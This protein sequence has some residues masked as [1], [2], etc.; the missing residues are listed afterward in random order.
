MTKI[1]LIQPRHNYAPAEGPGHIYM[2]T[3][4][5]TIAARLL[6][7]GIDVK[8]FDENLNPYSGSSNIVG[9]NLLGAP[10][11]PEAIKLENKI[12]K[13]HPDAK[14]LLGGQVISGL[15]KPQFQKLFGATAFNGNN[16]VVLDSTLGITNNLLKRAEKI[17][18]VPAYE[19][20]DDGD[21]R[22]Y[23]KREIGLYVSQGCRYACDFCPAVR[24]FKDPTTGVVKKVQEVYR[25]QSIIGADLNY[26]V[27]RAKNL[28]L[29]GLSIYMSNL[30]VFQ[31]HGELA[32]FT[33]AARQVRENHPDFK[34]KFRGLSTAE[35][36]VDLSRKHPKTIED[37]VS[38]GFNT[39][40]FGVDGMTPQVWNALHKGMNTED[41]CIE[42]IR[43]ARQDFGITPE[44]LMVFGHMGVDNH[45]TMKLAYKFTVDMVDKYGAIPRPHV[46]K[47]FVPGNKGWKMS[48]NQEAIELMVQSPEL[49][50][51]LDFTALPSRLTHRHKETKRLATKYFLKICYLPSATTLF[52]KPITPEMTLKQ[53]EEVKKFNEG[54]YD[55]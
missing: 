55:H 42:A 20:I 12:K 28:G 54:R 33:A 4:L 10:Y 14:F 25:D 21:M 46:A 1:D 5:L 35:S 7:S 32:K 8:I 11:I 36:F 51:A 18:L 3:S 16:D 22:E 40:G 38:V 24:T 34:I 13:N 19:K 50:Q 39:V 31:T 29:K 43:S 37:L 52:V 9:I 15:D 26:L 41:K 45:D 27:E 49:F 47:S 48:H 53:I 30:D 44:I 17:S 23:L 6:D 2:P